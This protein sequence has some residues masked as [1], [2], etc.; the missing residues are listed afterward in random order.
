MDNSNQA[1]ISDTCT[2]HLVSCTPGRPPESLYAVLRP[3]QRL[4]GPSARPHPRRRSTPPFCPFSAVWS[5]TAPSHVRTRARFHSPPGSS[6][7]DRPRRP[8]PS[9]SSERIHAHRRSTR[10]AFCQRISTRVAL[11]GARARSPEHRA[12]PPIRTSAPPSDTSSHQGTDTTLDRSPQVSPGA[13][14]AP[15]P[16]P[17]ASKLRSDESSGFSDDVSVTRA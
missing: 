15:A 7:R 17:S 5:R 13:A 6:P 10:V 3:S 9:R 11:T 2:H 16:V 8:S 4:T 1:D 14:H 12:R